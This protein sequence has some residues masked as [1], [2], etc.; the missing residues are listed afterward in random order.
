SILAKIEE[1]EFEMPAQIL[2]DTYPQKLL[3]QRVYGRFG[4]DF[5]IRFDFLDTMNGQNLSLQVHPTLDYAYRNFGAKYT[6]D[7]SYYILDCKEGA[8]VYLGLK[9]NVSRDELVQALENAQV[10]GEFP[11]EEF[12][13]NFKVNKHDH[14]LIPAGTVHSSGKNCVVLEIARLMIYISVSIGKGRS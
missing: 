3:G 6:Q 4:K 13:N 10:S 7:E 9:N 11:D 5:P 8:S 1:V 2:V 14:I 12:V